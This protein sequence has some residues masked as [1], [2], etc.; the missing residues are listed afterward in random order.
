[1]KFDLLGKFRRFANSTSG[2][3]ECAVSFIFFNAAI[4]R[5]RKPA[6]SKKIK[7][8]IVIL[9]NQNQTYHKSILQPIQQSIQQKLVQQQQ[10]PV[11][12]YFVQ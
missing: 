3:R 1:M 12:H 8:K 9:K 11:I 6:T 4:R 7:L 2:I 10:L 5:R